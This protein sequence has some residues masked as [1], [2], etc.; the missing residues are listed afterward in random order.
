MR[1]SG[2]NS[3]TAPLKA[4]RAMTRPLVK[5]Q[6]RVVTVRA[7]CYHESVASGT[8][9]LS[10]ASWPRARFCSRQ[11]LPSLP[12]GGWSNLAKKRTLETVSSAPIESASGNDPAVTHPKRKRHFAMIRDFALADVITLANGC[13][14]IGS[15]FA[16]QRFLI[17]RDLDWIWAAIGLLPLAGLF[18]FLDGRVARWRRRHTALGAQLDSLADLISFGVAPAVLGFALGLRGGWDTVIL[19]YFVSCGLS[20]LA[21]YNVTAAALADEQGKV[22]YFEG[23][24]IPTSIAIVLLWA[25]LVKS[26]RFEVDLPGGEAHWFGFG[27]HPLSLVYLASGSAMISKTLRVP[28]F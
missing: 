2:S 11:N 6:A 1:S 27:L 15:V 26:G 21:R 3:V 16:A 23:T 25:W 17:D 7:P 14:G 5:I 8:A 10:L 9:Q 12:L 18:D 24:P 22:K 28:K 13:A 19:I 20:R 4:N